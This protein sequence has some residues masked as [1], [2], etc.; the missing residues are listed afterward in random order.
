MVSTAT[1]QESVE[2]GKVYTLRDFL[3]LTNMGTKGL[4]D[5]KD[6]GLRVV[7]HGRTAYVSGDD[8]VDWIHDPRRRTT[9]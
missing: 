9:R 8:F 7:Y 5:A 6:D 2:R 4:R 1:K 3:R